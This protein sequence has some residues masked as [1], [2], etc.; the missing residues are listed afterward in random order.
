MDNII[1]FLCESKFIIADI[2]ELNPNVMYELGVAH[3]VG[4]ETIMIYE[5]KKEEENVKFPFDLAHHIRHIK[6]QDTSAGGKS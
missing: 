6:Y 3:T 5:E 1:I 2:S 4:K